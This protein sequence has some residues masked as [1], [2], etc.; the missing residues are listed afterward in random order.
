M[1]NGKTKSDK[2][3]LLKHLS[4]A[5]SKGASNLN[6]AMI[7]K[8]YNLARG[9]GK[10]VSDKD[11][12]NALKEVRSTSKEVEITLRGWDYKRK[13]WHKKMDLARA[14]KAA[15]RGKEMKHGGKATKKKYGVVGKPSM[16]KKG[17]KA[18]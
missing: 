13:A 3:K 8:A 6:K 11:F 10:T 1:A 17:G 14:K 12:K 15:T 2:D 18:K 4:S 5:G 16:L 7:D 9:K